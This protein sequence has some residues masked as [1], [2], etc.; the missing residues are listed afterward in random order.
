[1]KL[2]LVLW[3]MLFT[4]CSTL[5]PQKKSSGTSPKSKREV[6]SSDKKTGENLQKKEESAEKQ[7]EGEFNWFDWGQSE[8][9]T[10]DFDALDKLPIEEL[11]DCIAALSLV[12]LKEKDSQ[13]F[14]NSFKY[15]GN[16]LFSLSKLLQKKANQM[17]KNDDIDNAK[18]LVRSI[19]LAKLKK[20]IELTESLKEKVDKGSKVSNEKQQAFLYQLKQRYSLGKSYASLLKFKENYILNTDDIEDELNN[21]L[22]RAKKRDRQKYQ[23]D[24]N[25]LR[26]KYLA[27]KSSV[28][29]S[30]EIKRLRTRYAGVGVDDDIDELEK[31]LAGGSSSSS[32]DSGKKQIEEYVSKKEYLRAYELLDDMPNTAYKRK[33]LKKVGDGYCESNRRKAAKTFQKAQ[34]SKGADKE[35]LLENSSYL[36]EQCLKYFPE[37]KYRNKVIRN[38]E[39][40]DKILEEEFGGLLRF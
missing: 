30:E 17:L 2:V 23:K 10:C 39:Q 8:E 36:L 33:M 14:K 9:E 5:Q 32:A 38:K 22:E 20:T 11:E 13:V 40:I 4:A 35:K 26:D 34:K 1:M 19:N 27:N 31:E 6:P 29:I 28:S 12:D 15:Y 16:E 21:I 25:S 37:N 24:E 7:K 18:Q 3:V